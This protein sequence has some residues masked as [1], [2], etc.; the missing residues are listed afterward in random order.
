LYQERSK[1]HDFA[2]GRQMLRCSAGN[3]TAALA[4]VGLFERDDARATRVEMLHEALDGAALARRI[5][6]LEQDHHLLPGL[7][8]PGLQFELQQ[9]DL[10][11]S[12]CRAGSPS[13]RHRPW[14]PDGICSSHEPPP[15]SWRLPSEY[16]LPPALAT[17]LAGLETGLRTIPEPVFES[18][19]ATTGAF[20]P[21]TVFSLA[22]ITLKKRI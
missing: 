15:V 20:A 3:T 21:A 13:A 4:L 5:A 2:I 18:A 8:D 16:S 9:L 19:F 6:P 12:L 10:Q 14:R 1:K 22:I 17:G 11:R 7:L